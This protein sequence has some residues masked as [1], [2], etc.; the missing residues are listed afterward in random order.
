MTVCKQAKINQQ[1]GSFEF[2]IVLETTDTKIKGIYE[3]IGYVYD[4]P[5]C[6]SM[7]LCDNFFFT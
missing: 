7:N 2:M 4:M 6:I 1:K 3:T 5:A